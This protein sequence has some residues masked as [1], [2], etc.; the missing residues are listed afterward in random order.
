MPPVGP[1]AT[2]QHEKFRGFHSEQ[3]LPTLETI[4]NVAPGKGALTGRGLLPN[5]L[6]VELF[7]GPGLLQEFLV[8]APGHLLNKLF[9]SSSREYFCRGWLLHRYRLW[10]QPELLGRHLANTHCHFSLW[11]ACEGMRLFSLNKRTAFHIHPPAYQSQSSLRFPGFLLRITVNCRHPFNVLNERE[12][13]NF[14]GWQWG[15]RC[16]P[17]P[18]GYALTL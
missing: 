6:S 7:V 9:S 17:L 8:R 13:T 10:R 3:F 15:W 12:S 16:H 11:Q 18:K 4:F 14:G 2:Y 1:Q 5:S